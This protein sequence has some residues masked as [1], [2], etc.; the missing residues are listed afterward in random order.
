MPRR[1]KGCSS[2]KVILIRRM[3]SDQAAYIDIAKN[4]FTLDDLADIY[5]RKIGYGKIG[6]KAAGML[7]AGRIVSEVANEQ[8]RASI[9][10]PES[11]FL[12]SDVVYLFMA[13]N[14]LM[15]WNDQKYK[16]E[17]QIRQANINRSRLNSK[18]GNSPQKSCESCRK[19]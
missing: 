6:G 3:I 16:P 12:G 8:V 9:Q 17:P 4:W 10:I 7:L 19:S 1:N 5:Q 15:H 2:V 14:G 18:G 13:M 11:Y